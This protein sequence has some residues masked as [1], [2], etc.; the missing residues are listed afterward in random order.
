M[1]NVYSHFLRSF[2]CVSFIT[3]TFRQTV[4]FYVFKCF[5]E[6][7]MLR[8]TGRAYSLQKA[9]VLLS[10]HACVCVEGVD[11]WMSE[12]GKYFGYFVMHGQLS[13]LHITWVI[14]LLWCPLSLFVTHIII[15]TNIFIWGLYQYLFFNSSYTNFF[16]SLKLALCPILTTTSLVR[17]SLKWDQCW[18]MW[19]TW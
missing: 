15:M 16:F 17:V 4:V 13:F 14:W 3:G 2:S 9:L 11:E 12:C 6:R 1:N 5:S 10:V 7:N 18:N 8:G 19:F